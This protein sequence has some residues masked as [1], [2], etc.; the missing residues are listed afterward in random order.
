MTTNNNHNIY[1][2][3]KIIKNCY[4]AAAATSFIVIMILLL[5]FLKQI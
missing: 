2:Y 5:L 4:D 1:I 3:I